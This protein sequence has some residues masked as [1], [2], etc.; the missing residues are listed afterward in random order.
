LQYRKAI[1]SS[2][3]RDVEG[4]NPFSRACALKMGTVD[5]NGYRP[6]GRTYY[7]KTR[8]A[9]IQP[10]LGR[11]LRSERIL[12][13]LPPKQVGSKAGIAAIRLSHVEEGKKI[14]TLQKFVNIRGALHAS[15]HVPLRHM[16]EN[17]RFQKEPVHA[18]QTGNR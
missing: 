8:N 14:P 15:R 1:G 4:D 18:I 10:L 16:F 17:L 9:A 12:K 7:V 5:A 11:N 13:C 6:N 3:P 2:F